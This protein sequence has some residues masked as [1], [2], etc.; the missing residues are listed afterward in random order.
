MGWGG[1][2][3]GFSGGDIQKHP[4][5]CL[6]C[7]VSAFGDTVEPGSWKHVEP[8]LLLFQALRV[9][10]NCLPLTVGVMLFSERRRRSRAVRAFMASAPNS[11]SRQ[12]LLAENRWWDEHRREERERE[13]E[14]QKGQGGERERERE[15]ERKREGEK[16]EKGEKGEE[17]KERERERKQHHQFFMFQ[18][19]PSFT[20][21]SGI[22]QG[23]LTARYAAELE[24]C[25]GM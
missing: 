2:Y 15:K 5:L 25:K 21:T 7:S 4:A 14:K 1:G 24:D 9:A 23:M 22:L 6:P 13:G 16:G 20:V 18:P 17:E 8:L 19:S 12:Q 3:K 11:F 10:A